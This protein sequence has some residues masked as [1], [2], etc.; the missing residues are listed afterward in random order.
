MPFSS[1]S[2]T[3]VASE[4]RGGGWRELL[5]GT[6]RLQLQS[7]AFRER[8][9]HA[10]RRRRLSV[11]RSSGRLPGPAARRLLLLRFARRQA[12]GRHPAGKLRHRAFDAEH[13]RPGGDID[14]RLVEGGRR[15]L[16]GDEPVPDQSVER[17]LIRGEVLPHGFRIVLQRRRADRFVRV[18]RVRLRLVD[19]RLLRQVIVAE[20]GLDVI[21][22][23]GDRLVGDADRVGAHVGDEAA[24]QIGNLDAAFV[25]LLREHHRL[26]DG[27]ARPSAAACS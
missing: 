20:R 19:V 23:G 1:S 24:G 10:G 6:Q 2:L 26:L 3:S 14:R 11:V 8:R 15:H 7:I 21:A 17:I 18:L 4:K 16:R 25:E 12:V 13:V 22:D 27:K 5:L 9:Q